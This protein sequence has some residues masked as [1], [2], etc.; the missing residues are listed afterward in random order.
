MNRLLSKTAFILF[1]CFVFLSLNT[2]SFSQAEKKSSKDTS[3]VLEIKIDDQGVRIKA[4]KNEDHKTKKNGKI[5]IIAN[6][7]TT[8]DTQTSGAKDEDNEI[9]KV[10]EATVK[11][12]DITVEE[13]EKVEGDVTS[14]GGNVTVK[15][16]VEGNVV[17]IGGSI[18]VSSTG[19]IE[20]DATSIGGEIKIEPGGAIEGEKVSIQGKIPGLGIVT[21][22]H[23]PFYPKGFSKG[24][25]LFWRVIKILFLLFIGMVV[26]SVVPGNV[27]KVKD[28]IEKEF[29]KSTLFGFLGEILI[30]PIFV[31]LLI[32][33]IGIPVAILIEPIVVL[34][35]FVLGYTAVSLYIGEKLKQTTNVKPST[36][37]LTLFAGILAVEL[38]PLVG[39]ILGLAGGPIIIL[40]WILVISYWG[41][42]YVILTAGFG[43][44]ILSR[45]GTRPKPTPINPVETQAN[46]KP[47]NPS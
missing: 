32:T 47:A 39:R 7:P 4:Q 30:F 29:L 25:G 19:T 10:G 31:L 35:A 36:P 44:V 42:T 6:Q 45:F 14:I 15:G 43:G 11:M 28:K 3:K 27:S 8:V 12:G 9:K 41:I 2:I 18:L 20:E 34:V 22:P 17:A 5:E 33:I 26:L 16:A 38:I 21:N 23:S 46:N 24:M 13:E 1:V 40:T 37:L